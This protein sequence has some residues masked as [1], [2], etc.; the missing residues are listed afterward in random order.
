MVGNNFPPQS[1]SKFTEIVSE[2]Y[3]GALITPGSNLFYL[4]GLNPKNVME[5]LFI[6]IVYPDKKTVLISPDLYK[7]NLKTEW[8]DE[9][10]FWSDDDNPYGSLEKHINQI[11]VEKGKLLIEDDMDASTVIKL[12]GILKKFELVP[13]SDETSSLRVKKIDREIE[14]MKKAADIVDDIFYELIERDIEGK[15]EKNI[16]ALID[17][18]IKKREAEGPAFETI[19]ASGPNA[20]NPHHSPSNK[21]LRSGELVIMDFGAR[22]KGY[23]SDI[24][25]TV[26]IKE[27]SDEARKVYNTVKKAQDKACNIAEKNIKVST[28]DNAARD[29]IKQA[30]YG[31]YFTHRVGHGIGLDPHENPYLGSSGETILKNGM[32]FTI[33]PGI[34]ISGKIGVRIED[35]M[36]IRGEGKRL[37]KA[38]RDLKII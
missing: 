9:T 2:K 32:T 15:T 12:Q 13:V 38:D 7:D 29:I 23:C 22:Y 30:K 17:Y 4:T 3:D 28:V 5:R 16:A 24:T 19:V 36:V 31:K 10:I 33:E 11:D 26:A 37:T 18:M 6:F 21:K 35:D 25:R 14:Y 27:C 20:A 1:F 8:I 34:Y